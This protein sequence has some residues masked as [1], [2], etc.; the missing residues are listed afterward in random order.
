[1]TISPRPHVPRQAVQRVLDKRQG[2]ASG[3]PEEAGETKA[4]EE[5]QI[6][7]AK[8]SGGASEP[9]AP[10]TPKEPEEPASEPKEPASEPETPAETKPPEED[11][12][13]DHPPEAADQP[14]EAKAPAQPGAYF[15]G[16]ELDLTR[17]HAGKE[18]LL[19]RSPPPTQDDHTEG[20]TS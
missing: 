8:A 13:E 14:E 6:S 20:E 12:P 16:A 5:P 7:A 2:A 3:Q 1:M 9:A 17:P 15:I 18:K 10:A 11:A 4:P 19:P